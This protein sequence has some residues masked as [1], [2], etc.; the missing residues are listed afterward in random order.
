M[1]LTEPAIGG[2]A[3]QMNGGDGKG[4]K[5]GVLSLVLEKTAQVAQIVIAIALLV[6][7]HECSA[8]NTLVA[9]M[10]ID[11]G[12]NSPLTEILSAGIQVRLWLLRMP[13]SRL[14]APMLF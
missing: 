8:L 12:R 6:L 10:K 1:S 7:C 13:C 11:Q 3:W 14:R 5:I 9:D 4:S 2:S